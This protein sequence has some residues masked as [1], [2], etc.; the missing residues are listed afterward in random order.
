M[1]TKQSPRY[2]SSTPVS[3]VD[4]SLTLPIHGNSKGI[5]KKIEKK[6]YSCHCT[7]IIQLLK[8][9]NNTNSNTLRADRTSLRK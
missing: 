4:L 5:K 2:S 9:K 1:I 3:H 7:T 8:I 6:N